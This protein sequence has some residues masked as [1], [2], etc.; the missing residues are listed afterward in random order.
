MIMFALVV[1]IACCVLA[2]VYVFYQ[3][4]MSF[5]SLRNK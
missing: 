4:I 5:D 1:A 3:M 2:G